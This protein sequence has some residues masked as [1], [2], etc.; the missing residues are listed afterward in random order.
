MYIWGSDKKSRSGHTRSV[1]VFKQYIFFFRPSK[2]HVREVRVKGTGSVLLEYD[3]D[4]G[5]LGLHGDDCVA[6]ACT[7]SGILAPA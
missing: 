3:G 1:K 6:G 7:G 4:V 2:F 5:G